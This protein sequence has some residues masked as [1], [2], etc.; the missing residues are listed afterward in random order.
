[1]IVMTKVECE[2]WNTPAIT[3]LNVH[4]LLGSVQSANGSA[5]V[6]L[7]QTM[8]VCGIKALVTEPSFDQP[9]RGFIGTDTLAILF[10][11]RF[12]EHL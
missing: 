8:L 2:N 1:M 11:Y 3:L 9:N 5:L 4:I 7:G 6:R 10:N 12:H